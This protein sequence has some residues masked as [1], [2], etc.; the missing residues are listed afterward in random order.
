MD[1]ATAAREEVPAARGV[2]VALTYLHEPMAQPILA[3]NRLP[4]GAVDA[5]GYDLS[6]DRDPAPPFLNGGSVATFAGAARIGDVFIG[7][8]PGE[9]FP[10]LQFY[11][12][13]ERSVDGARAWFHLGATNDFLGCMIRPLGAYPQVAAEGAGY[14]LGCPEEELLK[15]T[16]VPYDDACP[17]HWTLT[18][19]PTIGS[20]VACTIQDAALRLGFSARTRDEACDALTRTDGA[21]APPEA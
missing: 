15:T 16:G 13:D 5:G 4:E 8:S 17:D 6:I 3:L 21:G 10:Q 9:P 14:L 19:S 18:V 11:L 7:L 12:R 1:E 20:H 2:G